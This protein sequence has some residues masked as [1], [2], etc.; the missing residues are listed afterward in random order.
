MSSK[1]L[2][3]FTI[4]E[5]SR[6]LN[7]L[8]KCSGRAAKKKDVTPPPFNSSVDFVNVTLDIKLWPS[9]FPRTGCRERCLAGIKCS[10]ESSLGRTLEE[11]GV[12]LVILILRQ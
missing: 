10:R 8:R 4:L 9:H 12:L 7:F 6:A 2:V 11:Q 3:Y 1:F 5:V